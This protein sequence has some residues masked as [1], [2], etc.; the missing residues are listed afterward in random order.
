MR[1]I[2]FVGRRKELEKLEEL[3]AETEFQMVI[4]YGRRRVGK[5]TLI[6]EFC[7]NK[8]TIFC[9]GIESTGK[10]NL[11]NFSKEVWKREGY[12]EDMPS[13]QNF[14][15]LFSH[16]AKL[17]ENEQVVFV[18][19]EYPYLAEAVPA[20]SSILQTCI[21]HQLLQGKMFLILCGSSM[22]FMEHQVLGYKSPLY[23]RRTAQF[24]ILP[25]DFWESCLM[26]KGFSKEEQAILYGATGG[27]PE[28]LRHIR[29]NWSVK[30][31]LIE[32]FFSSSGRLF[33]EPSNL[34]KQELRYPATYNAILTAIADGR[35]KQNEIAATVGIP[36]GGCSNLLKS[37]IE[38]GIVAK[39][40][41]VT[42]QSSKKT[43][44]HIQDQMFRFWY[45]FV[46]PNVSMITAGHGGL[47]Y[48]N[49][50]EPA[51]SDFMGNVFEII[52]ADWMIKQ[53]S[54]GEF[55]F[56][57]SQIG[58]W[59]GGNPRTHIQEGIDIMAIGKD[60]A[61][62][63]ECKWTNQPVDQTVLEKLVERA[64]LFTYPEKYL[65]V[66]S[67]KGFTKGCREAA[68]EDK[69]VRLIAFEEM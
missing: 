42:E 20:V 14:E 29:N 41:P 7:K 45:R 68:E 44:Y 24:R 47:V 26:L 69:R 21:D 54:K 64:G 37:L 22:S 48:D 60:A 43:I 62:F 6:N 63:G 10:E 38:L 33:E 23:G 49:L 57:F 2:Q 5:T 17:A 32:L 61:A 8:K 52:T 15:G 25:F 4:I 27:I 35:S 51:L 46:G 1:E 40:T 58:C 3:Y 31:N 12:E 66:F 30:K 9:V 53:L 65:Y 59:W 18:I 11:D 39:E 36:T 19:D 50:V 28:Y 55:P 16:A 13:F 34:L 56:F 67:K